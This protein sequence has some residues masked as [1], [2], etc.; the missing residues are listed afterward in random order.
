MLS[1][2]GGRA[3]FVTWIGGKNVV[4]IDGRP[5][6]PF[7]AVSWPLAMSEK[8]E[9]VAFAAR[10][11]D[12]QICVAG[13]RTYGPYRAVDVPVLSGDGS[14]V[15]FAAFDG[16]GWRA[17]VDGEAGPRYAWVGRLAL[18][19]DGRALAYAAERRDG[20]GRF[21]AFVVREGREGPVFDRVTAPVLSRDGGVVAYGGRRDG[22]WFLVRGETSH[23]VQGEIASVFLD[24]AGRRAGYVRETGEG[25]R[26]V[27]PS[28]EGACFEWVGWPS[29]TDAGLEVYLAGRGGRRYLVAGTRETDLGEGVVWG[30]STEGPAA[31]FGMR[32]G[33]RLTWNTVRLPRSGED[34][35]VRSGG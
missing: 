11:G 13:G 32:R 6:R 3:A 14:V 8:G 21:E 18:S 20:A 16:Q 25:V 2:S 7:D 12:E 15:A 17:V 28:G 1:R 5:G 34:E 35:S 10:R 23:P 27:G 26:V 9:V 4:V 30:L 24:P 31:Q 22:Q 29:L 33:R 19:A